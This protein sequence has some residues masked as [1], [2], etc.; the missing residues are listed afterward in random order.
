MSSESYYPGIRRASRTYYPTLNSA[1]VAFGVRRTHEAALVRRV[2]E[3]YIRDGGWPD[4]GDEPFE[5]SVNDYIELDYIKLWTTSSMTY[6]A[7]GVGRWNADVRSADGDMLLGRVTR[8][9]ILPAS[10]DAAYYRSL[11]LPLPAQ[12]YPLDALTRPELRR[13]LAKIGLTAR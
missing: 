5:W 3:Q 11:K 1:L 12:G 8:T 6:L 9:R 7:I 13:A 4:D 2:L 10:S